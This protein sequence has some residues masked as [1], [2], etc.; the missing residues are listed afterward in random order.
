MN[1]KLNVGS[2]FQSLMDKKVL[3]VFLPGKWSFTLF[4]VVFILFFAWGTTFD[5][6]YDLKEG[7]ITSG[8]I[9]FKIVYSNFIPWK[10]QLHDLRTLFMG[11]IIPLIGQYNLIQWFFTSSLW[12]GIHCTDLKYNFLDY[13]SVL[14]KYYCILIAFDAG[15]IFS[16][17]IFRNNKEVILNSGSLVLYRSIIIM[18]IV[19]IFHY[20]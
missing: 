3:K 14:V 6:N 7:T 9:G 12:W 1:Y 13:I 15:A 17:A 2:I 11:E 8:D 19:L 20:W 5:K 10:P 16:M 4:L 18:I